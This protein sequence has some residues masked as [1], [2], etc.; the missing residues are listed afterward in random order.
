MKNIAVV[1]GGYSSEY[2]VSVK[3]AKFIYDNLKD[4]SDWNIYEI[5]ISKKEKTVKFKE[6]IFDLDYQNFSFEIDGII[7]KPDAV[8]NI[9]HGDPGEN[10]VLAEILEKN[11]IPQTGCDN[12]VSQL[13]FNKKKFIEFVDNLDIPCAKQ[14]LLKKKEMIDIEK[15]IETIKLPCIVKP[16][17]GGSSI[18]VSKV[19]YIDELENKIKIAFNEDNQVLIETFLEGQ[20]VSVGV[21][22]RN[23][24]RIILPITEIISEN[25]L[26]DYNAKYLGESQEITPGNISKESEALIHKYIAKIYDNIEL[27]GITRSEFII[28]N[29]IPH[30][31]ETNTIPGFT[32]QSIIPQQIE[33]QKLSVK[34]VLCNQIK[35]IL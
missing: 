8:F 15:I 2:D 28:V 6:R 7:I 30:I 29:Q 19:N 1:F 16:N 23:G 11:Q 12:Y 13:T 3:S 32:K 5:C 14:I 22:N 20:E 4:N 24:K 31:L 34:E 9:I 33:V 25:E 10:G 18:G 35:L 27:N 17:N 21:I 26:F